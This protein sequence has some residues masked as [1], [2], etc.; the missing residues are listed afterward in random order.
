MDFAKDFLSKLVSFDTS[1]SSQD[2]EEST[3]FYKKF[4]EEEI[5]MT[6]KVFPYTPNSKKS[7]LLAYWSD[8]F[9]TVLCGHF[10]TVNADKTK[11]STDPYT[12]TFTEE[13][14]K[15]KA[16]GLGTTDMKGGNVSAFLTL[17]KLKE[18]NKKLDSLAVFFSCEEE[19]AVRGA[20][21]ITA[22]NKSLF[23]NVSTYIILEPTNL[24]LGSSQFGHFWMKFTCTGKSAHASEPERGINAIEGITDLNYVLKEAI[25][26]P[27]LDGYVTLNIG[28]IQGGTQMNIVPDYCEE[29][30]DYRFA[31][32]VFA[33][34][35]KEM[36]QHVIEQMNEISYAQ[37]SYEYIS[38]MRSVQ[39]RIT[40][41]L[42]IA[43][44]DLLSTKYVLNEIPM[45]YG[46]DG[47][48]FKTNFPSADVIIFGPGLMGCMHQPNEFV[49][50][51]DIVT[52]SDILYSV[53][54]N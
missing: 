18:Q 42:Y 19:I 51:E 41:Q 30:V 44:K 21:D 17:K 13:S 49:F 3:L 25:H 14:G 34:D 50:I 4:L 23:E 47:A 39:C 26:G 8:T 16:T 38:E 27:E 36:F 5:G 53:L 32:N 48:V 1:S 33:P 37:Y 54:T 9:T 29:Y 40:N 12:V 10:D 35:M 11:W 31:P 7:N 43:M 46:S 20:K 15:I 6:V 45:K 52:A 28:K 24:S 2:N 22:K